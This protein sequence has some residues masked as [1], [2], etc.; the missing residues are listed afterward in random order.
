MADDMHRR[1]VWVL[2]AA[3]T[4]AALVL[5]Y[6]GSRFL[7]SPPAPNLEK[8]SIALPSVPHAALLH[9]AAAKGYFAEEGLEVTVVPTIHG[10]AA[11]DLM[12]QGKADLGTASEVVFVLAAMKGGAL[13][14]AAN[15]FSSSN[16]LAVIARRDRGISAPRDLAGKKIGVSLG[17]AGEY[18]LW[19]LLIRHKLPPGSV[20]LV[21]MPPGQFAQEL[22]KGTL[23]AVATWQPNVLN[24]QLALDDNA[25]TFHEPL[26]YTET[27]NVIGRSD[28]LKGHSKAIEKLVRAI[29]KAEQFNRAQPEE[30]L[31]L[32]AQLL[33]IDVESMR[34]I[35]KVL[36]FRVDLAQSQLI[37]LEDVA[38]WALAR[39]YAEK[40]SVPNF[41][42]HLYLDALLAVQPERVT[43][44]R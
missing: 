11:I 16:D 14:I 3:F 28:F 15:M 24:A 7:S 27:F 37:T 39:G 18:F 36:S 19:A 20:T 9:I 34:P 13:G 41:L 29:L 10:K 23:D 17:T 22:T 21:D 31:N 42:P 12:V 4:A 1:R 43:V 30:A 35:W 33:K 6:L 40:G 32:V 5:G 44:V 25:V 26:A 38:R 2:A 8:L